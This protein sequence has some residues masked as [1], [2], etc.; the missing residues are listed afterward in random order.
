[1]TS[2]RSLPL[3][4]AH[5]LLTHLLVLS[6]D[7][8]AEGR[9]LQNDVETVQR[10]MQDHINRIWKERETPPQELAGAVEKKLTDIVP[11]PVI[12]SDV[13]WIFG[14]LANN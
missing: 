2:C 5:S 12:S 13:P 1:M 14:W 11:K 10:E 6:D 7:L 8:A 9:I 4:E 3:A